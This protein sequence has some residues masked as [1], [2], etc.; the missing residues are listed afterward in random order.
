MSSIEIERICN[1]VHSTVLETAAFGVP[2]VGGGPEQ[3]VLAVVY[4]DPN[5]G[6]DSIDHL[7]MSFNSALQKKLNPLFKVLK[8]YL[9]P[10]KLK[11]CV[12]H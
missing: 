7:K 6:P 5:N 2:P 3:L 12:N 8:F 11:N 4:K 9:H 10:F 1:D